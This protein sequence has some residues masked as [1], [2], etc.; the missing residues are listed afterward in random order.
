MLENIKN[1]K[2]LLELIE[3]SDGLQPDYPEDQMI[4]ALNALEE[5]VYYIEVFDWEQHAED[6]KAGAL[7]DAREF[8]N[9]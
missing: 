2:A 3:K 8:H 9:D 6:L 1:V 5:A 4:T 7:C